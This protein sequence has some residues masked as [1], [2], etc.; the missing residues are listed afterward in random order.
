MTRYEIQDE[1]GKRKRK[2]GPYRDDG[3]AINVVNWL[4]EIGY[5]KRPS[6]PVRLVRIEEETPQ[7]ADKARMDWLGTGDNLNS[8]RAINRQEGT[9]FASQSSTGLFPT[10]RAA[11]DHARGYTPKTTV[12]KEYT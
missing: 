4:L 1:D 3:H 7:E 10:L 11:I 9:A 5:Y 8:I 6:R 12:I 2:V